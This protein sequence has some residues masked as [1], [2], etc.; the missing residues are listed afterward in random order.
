MKA[1]HNL[2]NVI[3]FIKKATSPY[4][5]V[6]YSAS[7]LEENEFK[8]LDFSS[9][10]DLEPGKSYYTIPAGTT[11][12]AFRIPNKLTSKSI[13]RIT[14]SH[15]DYPCLR[16]KPNPDVHTN[17]YHK[18]NVETY[19]GAILNTWLDRPLSAAGLVTLRSSSPFNPQTKLVD[20]KRPLVTIPNL[21]IH[22]NRDINK[23][24]ELNKQLH[25]L[26]LFSDSDSDLSF[27]EFLGK[28]LD[29]KASDILDYDLYIYN[30]EDGCTFG[31][32]QQYISSPRL[33]N[34]SSVFSQITG[35]LHWQNNKNHDIS[36]ALFF[37]NEEIGS[38]T[39][40]GADS[41]IT[42][43]LLEK[44][45]HGLKIKEKYRNEMI[46]NSFMI[47]ADVAHGVH[48]NYS[49]KSDITN[50]TKINK[51]F[52]IKLNYN[53]KYATDTYAI[54]IVQQLCEKHKI[55]Y[56]KFVNRSD[57]A[58]GGTLGTITSSWLPMKT[59]DIGIPILAM[60]S[61]R[62][63]CGTSDIQSIIDF[64]KAFYNEK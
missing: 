31:S 53:Q 7:I 12:F 6:E 26:P 38:R 48:P 30:Q 51:G 54:G 64:M 34:L 56:Q 59:V 63:T 20:F 17:G 16:I 47:S 37:D 2:K 13:F 14:A 1:I 33:D 44:I 58:G 9:P 39:K 49:E 35:L 15:T 11:L 57:I 36:M 5:V 62:E 46:Y 55:P 27:N 45:Q 42:N 23:G 50:Y 4:H 24:A 18:L 3:D 32:N 40:Q 21:A 41:M 52:A 28:E 25:L 60:H 19:G 43:M 10:W 61:A 22:M 29:V 8:K